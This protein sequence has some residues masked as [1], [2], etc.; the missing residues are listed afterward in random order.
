MTDTSLLYAFH[1]FVSGSVSLAIA[2]LT[3]SR[4]RAPGGLPLFILLL[5]LTIWSWTYALFW[6][7]PNQPFP[8]FW[9]D[10]TYFG[11]LGVPVNI[12]IFACQVSGRRRWIN[13]TTLSLLVIEPMLTLILLWSDPLHN[14]FYGG[15]RQPGATRIFEGGAWFWVNVI[16]SYSL[17]LFALF[18]FARQAFSQRASLFRKQA[19]WMLAGISVPLIA[20]V[21]GVFGI[22]AFPDLDTTPVLFTLTGIFFAISFFRYQMLD[23]L[24]V[25]KDVLMDAMRD[26]LIVVD[27]KQRIVDL[28]R[29][30]LDLLPGTRTDWIGKPLERIGAAAPEFLAALLPLRACSRQVALEIPQR[31]N[32]DVQATPYYSRRGELQGYLIVWRDV[33]ALM[34][35]EHSLRRVNE[36]LMWRLSEIQQLQASLREQV[37]RDPLTGLFNRRFL[38]SALPKDLARAERRGMSVSFLL[39]DIDLFKVIN[40]RFGHEAGDEVL[41]ELAATLENMTRRGDWVIR[42]GGEEFLVV[43][44]ETTQQEAMQRAEEIRCQV[45][46]LTIPFEQYQLRVTVSIGLAVYPCHGCSFKELFRAAD[47]ALYEAKASGRNTV[48]AATCREEPL[49]LTK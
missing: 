33:S 48:V 42:Y 14:L 35:A 41:R 7:F 8:H 3:W 34:R 17:L 49:V 39:L 18:L 23:I 12:F 44:T 10:V 4:R 31:A 26:G 40:D 5:H 2:A 20:N 45:E 6:L 47:L 1:L 16:Y 43:M 24:P 29:T 30:A 46:E 32:L 38:E 9:L 19:A 11:V 21:L 37:I 36:E 15:L 22:F 25:G 28:N 13:R 27:V